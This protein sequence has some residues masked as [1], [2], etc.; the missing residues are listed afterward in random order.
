MTSTAAPCRR[1]GDESPLAHRL[2]RAIV[3]PAAQSLQNLHVADGSVA[4]HDDLEHDVAGDAAAA[5][6]LGVVGL[7]FTQQARRLDA[8]AGTIRPAAGAA[9]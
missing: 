7:H 8:A 5:R 2:H 6:V 9:A 1:A 4:A 3:Q